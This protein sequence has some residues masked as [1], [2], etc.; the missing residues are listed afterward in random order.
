VTWRRSIDA[1]ETAAAS[2]AAR[3]AGNEQ[4]NGGGEGERW[5]GEEE[6]GGRVLV[7]FDGF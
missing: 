2:P 1:V 7:G 5:R 3:T 4:D 6:E